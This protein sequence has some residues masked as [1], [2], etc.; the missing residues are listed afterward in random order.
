MQSRLKFNGIYKSHEKFD[1]YIFKQNE[2]LM[3][4]PNYLGFSVLELN[5]LLINET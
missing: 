2:F 4:K 5:G 3:D 1:S